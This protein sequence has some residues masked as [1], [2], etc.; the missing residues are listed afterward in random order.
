MILGPYPELY[1]EPCQTSKIEHFAK[2]VDGCQWVSILAKR[3]KMFNRV[4]NAPPKPF[5]SFVKRKTKN[6]L[7]TF[8]VEGFINKENMESFIK[9]L[10]GSK[11]INLKKF[12][13]DFLKTFFL[14]PISVNRYEIRSRYGPGMS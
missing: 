12:A 1:L 3:S 8:A 7:F 4:L 9:L 13:F 5:R 10:C 14:V 6:A 2:I 11:L